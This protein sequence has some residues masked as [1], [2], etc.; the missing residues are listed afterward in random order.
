MRR[1]QATP[2]KKA[3]DTAGM[4]DGTRPGNRFLPTAA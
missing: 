2:R 4:N 3:P 1:G